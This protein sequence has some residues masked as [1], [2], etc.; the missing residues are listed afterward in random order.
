MY[1]I[2]EKLR[3]VGAWILMAALIWG[4]VFPW[5][6]VKTVLA[7]SGTVLA[8]SGE[9]HHYCID[10]SGYAHN[11]ASTKN[12]KYMRVNTQ[13]GLNS[14]ERAI[15]FCAMLSFKAAYCHVAAAA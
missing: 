4:M 1:R 5:L 13:D 8:W 14:Q 10:G 3:G 15:L 12:D 2:K 6:P 9:W 11:T 7:D